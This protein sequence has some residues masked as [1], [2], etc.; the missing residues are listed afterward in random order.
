MT[1]PREVFDR[2]SEGIS[3]GRFDDLSQLYAENAVVEHPTAIPRPTK[4]EG[5]AAVHD[6]FV[7]ALATAFRV[8]SH[9]V[10]VHETTD[11]EVIVAEYA[12]TAESRST[13]KT[14]E[15]PNIQVLRVRDAHIVHS[16][17]YHDYLRLAAV[18]GAAEGLAG[19]Y[20]QV[21]AHEPGS[22]NPRP[23]Q[24]GDRM[25]PLGVFQRLCFGVSDRRWAE[26]PELYAEQTDVRHP[27]LPGSPVL[28]S[29]ADLRDHFE[30]AG[31]IGINLQATDLV[32][33]QSTDPEVLIGEFAYEGELGD[34][35][36][37]RVNNIFVLRV[38]NGL[39]VES[40]DYGDHPALAAAAGRLPELVAS[41]S[42]A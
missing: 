3:D 22:A 7:G 11:P 16:R 34:G 15:V 31:K 5:R 36:P 33:H 19:A 2:L 30:V 13:G 35:T 9:D 12:Y 23:A 40:R 27:F 18:Q 21:P 14:G 17:D 6:R 42:A 20:A 39:I 1:T 29:R 28:R 24:L 38:R 10:V 8:K 26:L 32:A 4:L 25:S 41:V 37:L